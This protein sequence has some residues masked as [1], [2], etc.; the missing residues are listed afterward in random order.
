M[1]GW[2]TL[3]IQRIVVLRVMEITCTAVF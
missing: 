3:N 1:S 2:D